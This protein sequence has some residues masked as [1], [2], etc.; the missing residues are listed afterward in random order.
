MPNDKRRSRSSKKTEAGVSTIDAQGHVVEAII[1]VIA[2]EP[3]NV[4]LDDPRYVAWIA[5]KTEREEMSDDMMRARGEAL[6]R[7]A[8]GERKSD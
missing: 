4:A 7:S 3:M 6:M 1:S 5:A 8:K 2:S